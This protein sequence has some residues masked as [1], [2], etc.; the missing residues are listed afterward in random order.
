MQGTK[1]TESLAGT[2]GSSHAW[3]LVKDFPYDEDVSRPPFLVFSDSFLP[4]LKIKS[5]Y[6]AVFPLKL[7]LFGELRNTLLSAASLPLPPLAVSV[8]FCKTFWLTTASLLEHTLSLVAMALPS[9]GCPL[10]LFP[11]R[12]LCRLLPP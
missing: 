12:L 3:L 6:Q 7:N 4:I 10:W 9:P 2:P 5:S 11:L 8:P 1:V